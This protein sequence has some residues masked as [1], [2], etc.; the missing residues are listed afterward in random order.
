MGGVVAILGAAL[1]AAAFGETVVTLDACDYADPPAARKAWRPIDRVTP[2]A[3][4]DG[5]GLVLRCNFGDHREWRVAWDRRGQWDLSEA[6]EIVIDLDPGPRGARLVLHLRSEGG[7]YGQSFHVPPGARTARLARRRFGVEG[8][9]AGWGR[10]TGLR[11]SVLR[12]D[13]DRTV[14]VTG[15]RAVARPAYVAVYRNDAGSAD[16]P[17]VGQWTAAM[18]DLLERVGLEAEVLDDGAVAGGRLEGKRVAVLPL[19][20]VLPPPAERALRTFAAGGGKLLVCYRLPRPLG[21]LLGVQLTGRIDPA[22]ERLHTLVFQGRSDRPKVR[23]VQR[24]WTAARL[25]PGPDARVVGWWID[26]ARPE[27]KL[28]AVTRNRHG[29]FVAHVL[30]REDP[31]GKARL[32]LEMLGE[33]W[34]TAWRL[35]YERR[36]AGLDGLA[37]LG[38]AKLARAARAAAGGDAARLARV[39]ALLARADA[40]VGDAASTMKYGDA[41]VSA[42]LVERAREAY[43]RAYAL[44]APAREGEFRGVWCHSPAGVAGRTWDEALQALAEAGFNAI[45]VNMCW[46]GGAA[47]PSKLLPQVTPR[48]ELSACLAAAAG[49]GL[50]VHVWRVN[51]KLWQG[52]PKELR[53]KL[54]S[55]GRLQQDPAGEP[56]DWLCPSSEANLAL[57]REAMLEIVRDYD[58]A[59]IHFDY[60]RYPGP[61]GCYCPRCRQAF[62][63]RIGAKVT[64]WP[65]DVRGG[66]LREEYLQFRRDN[67]TRLVAAVAQSA[68]K[69]RPGVRV[70]AAVFWHWPSARDSVGQDW[71]LWVRKGYLDFVCPMQYTP[72]CE[73]FEDFTAQ[74]RDWAAGRCPL[75]PGIGATLGQTPEATLRQVL[76]ARR[77]GAAGFVLFNYDAQLAGEHLPLLRLGATAAKTTWPGPRRAAGTE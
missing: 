6:R 36:L 37:G 4:A 3:E 8:R 42:E 38:R 59:G 69:L 29:F 73:L 2:P 55:A 48:D 17:G 45:L 65:A 27:A 24:S 77:L 18:L 66:D 9:P 22:G 10:I 46:G 62:E 63:K 60:I 50:D 21:E 53:Q 11:L 51:W 30:T 75:M 26:P 64:D 43:V 56:I 19:N 33:L 72:Q 5:R 23:A 25:A 70:S 15:I 61:Q 1:G 67:I 44:S 40:L 34:P 14:R 68:R 49:H 16:E 39:N 54:R 20:P 28:P 32:L 35:G 12:D 57:E 52:T 58:V 47:Y 31:S 74:T 7:W 71:R 41:V 76:A 13:R